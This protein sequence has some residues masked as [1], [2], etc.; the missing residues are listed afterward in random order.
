MFRWSLRLMLVYFV[1]LAVL[2][3]AFVH[4]RAWTLENLSTSS[5]TEEWIRWKESAK[6]LE[7]GQG[8]VQRRAPRAGEPPGL[9]LLRDYTVTCFAAVII[10][11]TL[12]FGATTIALRG[13]FA[14][15]PKIHQNLR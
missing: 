12:L 13:V 15:S 5:A 2:S 11:G 7:S 4:V 8:P 14:A 6:K 3:S 1:F 10:F 9:I